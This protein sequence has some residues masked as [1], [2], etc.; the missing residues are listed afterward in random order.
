LIAPM[1]FISVSYHHALGFN[2]FPTLIKS[3]KLK[4]QHCLI[5]IK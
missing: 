5:Q 4:S 1:L 2:F 3:V